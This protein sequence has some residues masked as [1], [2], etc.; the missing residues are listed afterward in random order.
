MTIWNY[1]HTQFFSFLQEQNCITIQGEDGWKYRNNLLKLKEIEEYPNR[2][3]IYQENLFIFDY[4]KGF[5]IHNLKNQ[6]K[7]FSEYERLL[8][9]FLPRI[10]C[11]SSKESN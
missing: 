7:S 5:E 1:E 4:E 6:N 8:R 10:Y 3:I 11:S 9:S 2:P